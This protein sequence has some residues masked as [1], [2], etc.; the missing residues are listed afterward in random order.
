MENSQSQVD[1]H[2][3]K[4]AKMSS[5]PAQITRGSPEYRLLAEIYRKVISSVAVV[6]LA[7]SS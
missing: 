6:G 2:G 3:A 7:L 4:S 1:K 5:E